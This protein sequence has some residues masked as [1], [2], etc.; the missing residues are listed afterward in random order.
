[1]SNPL[2]V[3]RK[4]TF[5]WRLASKVEEDQPPKKKVIIVLG[6]GHAAG[7]KYVNGLVEKTAMPLSRAIGI[8]ADDAYMMYYNYKRAKERLQN[9]NISNGSGLRTTT[10]PPDRRKRIQQEI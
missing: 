5:P 8:Y 10:E 2:K 1:M 6:S 4:F 3:I 9:G 7:E